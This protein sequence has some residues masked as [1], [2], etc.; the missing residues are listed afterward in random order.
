MRGFP[1]SFKNS[2]VKQFT[3]LI[4]A[5]L[6]RGWTHKQGVYAMTEASGK[7]LVIGANVKSS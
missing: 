6:Y 5:S 2:A 1:G 7:L 3:T 4:A